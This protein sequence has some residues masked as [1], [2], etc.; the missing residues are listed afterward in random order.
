MKTTYNTSNGVFGI[1]KF[2]YV[3]NIEQKNQII[4]KIM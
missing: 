1:S 2:V 4:Q 3:C